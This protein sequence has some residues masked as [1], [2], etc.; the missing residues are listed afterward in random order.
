[1]RVYLPT[2]LPGLRAAVAAGGFGPAPLI[3]YGVT[4]A[5]REWY[6][7]GDL[8][9]LEY[10]AMVD[11]SRA[12]LRLLGA[13]ASPPRRVVV[14]VDVPDRQVEPAPE[15]DRGAVRV[16]EEIPQ[17]RIVSAHVDSV[18]AEEAVIAAAAATTRAEFD[19]DAQFVVDGVEDHE[20]QWYAAQEIDDLFD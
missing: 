4:P 7:S 15:L 18:D 10:A 17:R 19:D 3:A 13:D 20:L 8:E 11:A 6:V 12:S 1:M 5:L 14:A 9:E 16:I 2:T